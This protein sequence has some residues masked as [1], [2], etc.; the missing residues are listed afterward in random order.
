MP[1]KH[2]WIG[3]ITS[4]TQPRV[5]KNLVFHQSNI[6]LLPPFSPF[7]SLFIEGNGILFLFR[8]ALTNLEKGIDHDPATVLSTAV[9]NCNGIG[10][11]H[12]LILDR[13]AISSV[14]MGWGVFSHKY[15]CLFFFRPR[16][17]SIGIY[18]NLIWLPIAR[19]PSVRLVR[20]CTISAKFVQTIGLR[21]IVIDFVREQLSSSFSS[22]SYSK[23]R[24]SF[25]PIKEGSWI[26]LRWGAPRGWPGKHCRLTRWCVPNS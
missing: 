5:F 26:S 23:F 12:C 8:T 21:Y 14:S 15:F 2:I 16:D 19:F 22:Y 20:I 4:K 17:W 18:L 3:A 7:Y 11:M 10:W 25:Q 1:Q 6:D 13:I 24:T 9:V